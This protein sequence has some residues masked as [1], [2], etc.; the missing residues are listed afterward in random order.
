MEFHFEWCVAHVLHR[1]RPRHGLHTLML[2]TTPVIRHEHIYKEIE[3]YLIRSDEMRKGEPR[4]MIGETKA[5]LCTLLMLSNPLLDMFG[6]FQHVPVTR[7]IVDEA[8]QIDTFE[9]MV[10]ITSNCRQLGTVWCLTNE[11]R[12]TCSTNL[13]K[14]RSTMIARLPSRRC[15]CS[16]TQSNVSKKLERLNQYPSVGVYAD[17]ARQYLHSERRSRLR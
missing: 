15:V 11:Q 7:L 16:A 1:Y 9:F 13:T 8:S 5:I 3:R 12:S 6:V 14:R 4:T 10:S 17:M 2:S